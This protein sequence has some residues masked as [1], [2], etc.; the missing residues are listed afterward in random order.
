MSRGGPLC[1]KISETLTHPLIRDEGGEMKQREEGD[2]ATRDDT[3]F[4]DGYGGDGAEGR[5][6]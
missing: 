3:K 5:F 6:A 4:P 2:S 1:A